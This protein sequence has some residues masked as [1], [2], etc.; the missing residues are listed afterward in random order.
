M[1]IKAKYENNRDEGPPTGY[2]P[3]MCKGGNKKTKKYR[4]NTL[5]ISFLD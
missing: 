1:N 5:I 4:I 3:G 2:V